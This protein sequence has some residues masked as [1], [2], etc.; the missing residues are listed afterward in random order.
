MYNCI[1]Q[2]KNQ[3]MKIRKNKNP[4]NKTMPTYQTKLKN[5]K[6]NNK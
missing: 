6:Y 5:N 4:Q 3:P 1:C 2:N